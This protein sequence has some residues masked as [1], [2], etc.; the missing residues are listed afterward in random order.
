[1]VLEI[2][3]IDV[4]AGSEDAFA[5]AYHQGRALLVESPGAHKVTM[6]RSIETPNR[7]VLMVEWDAV[8][9][10]DEFRAGPS[11]VRWRELVG[12]HFADKPRVEHFEEV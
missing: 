5:D 6:T 12:P 11:F 3:I 2:A 7:F 10:H 9:A 4:V 8:S 1:M